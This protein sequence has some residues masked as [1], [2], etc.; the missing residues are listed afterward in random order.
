MKIKLVQNYPTVLPK[1]LALLSFFCRIALGEKKP[2]TPHSTVLSRLLCALWCVQPILN[3]NIIQ[4]AAK[5]L[6]IV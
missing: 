4:L 1:V 3:Q 5:H 2:T 6:K